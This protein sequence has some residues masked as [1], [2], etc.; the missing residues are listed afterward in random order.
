MAHIEH[1]KSDSCVG[2][3]ACMAI[4]P[5]KAITISGDSMG[6]WTPDVKEDKCI[7]CGKCTASCQVS[8]PYSPGRYQNSAYAVR[9][10]DDA[11][12][13]RSAS[14]AFFQAIA[15]HMLD[16][17][18]FVCGCVMDF[19]GGGVH[20]GV[21]HILS[22][23]LRDVERMADSKYVQSDMGNCYEEV[24]KILKKGIPVLFSGASCQIMGLKLYLKNKSIDN[25]DLVCVDFFCH[26]VPSPAI[27]KDYIDH[28][29]RKTGRKVRGYRFRNKRNGWGKAAN[30]AGYFG[31][32]T[33]NAG[34]TDNDSFA[35]TMWNRKIFFSNL[36]IRKSCFSCM[37]AT[38]NKPSDITMADFWG[39]EN[40]SV[41]SFDDGK[42]T[43]LVITHNKKADELLKSLETIDYKK[44]DIEEAVAGQGNAFTP[45]ICPE[46]YDSFWKEYKEKGFEAVNK[47]YFCYNY[48]SRIKYWVKKF[49][50]LWKT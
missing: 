21:G 8:E 38:V 50:M 17:G 22:N 19:F 24:Y 30:G 34:K 41:A 6:F 1:M 13:Y 27:W 48:F 26:G 43:S 7:D 32:V 37:Y 4:C 2:C 46:Q 35:A 28:Y 47:K 39:I 23:Q 14:G 3:T 25:K 44:A 20:L 49:I 12:R 9:H 16:K 11:I 36:A 45:T 10:K 29:E 33:D 15:R 31:E 42:G 5:E 40:T 18:G